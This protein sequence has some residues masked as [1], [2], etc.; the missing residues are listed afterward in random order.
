MQRLGTHIHGYSE[1][2]NFLKVVAAVAIDHVNSEIAH[3][4][5][6]NLKKE[7]EIKIRVA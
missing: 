7:A 5:R 6:F 2:T 4:W 1:A 3:P